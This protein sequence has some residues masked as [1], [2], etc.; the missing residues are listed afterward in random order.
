MNTFNTVLDVLAFAFVMSG[1]A[2]PIV[3]QWYAMRQS[4]AWIGSES[5]PF[6]G[7][8]RPIPAD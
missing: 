8:W 5:R 7:G 1:F 3:V 6:S 4:N 2:S